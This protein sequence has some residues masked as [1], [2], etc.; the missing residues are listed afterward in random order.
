[1]DLNLRTPPVLHGTEMEQL[2]QVRSYLYQMHQALLITLD[3]I[4]PESIVLKAVEAVTGGDTLPDGGTATIHEAYNNLKALIIKTADTVQAEYDQLTQT[5]ESSYVA[6]S[7]FGTYVENASQQI[8][9]IATGVVQAFNYESW[10]TNLQDSLELLNTYNIESDQYIKTGL[11]F[12]DENNIP[13]Y[14]VA[15]GENLT[16]IEVDGETVI[17]RS[18]LA[19]TF[20]SDRLSF[21]MNGLE[22]AYLSN[23]E[24]IVQDIRV[25]NSVKIGNWVLDGTHGFSIRWAGE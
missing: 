9:A 24:L 20:T 4:N 10:L 5:L 13:R 21:W 19:A 7:S 3:N 8:E 25:M 23:N 6:V 14:G 17:E 11:L 16:R 18:G 22:V 15:V 1:M 2:T 12:F